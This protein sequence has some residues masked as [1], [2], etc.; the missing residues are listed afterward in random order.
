QVDVPYQYLTFFM[1]D[2]DELQRIGEEYAAG[3]MLT[4]EV[5]KILIEILTKMTK[6][7]Q[8]ARAAVTDEMV[9]SFMAVRPI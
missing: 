2:D 1:E 5:K 6:N 4:G 9:R 8:D 3:R 7:H